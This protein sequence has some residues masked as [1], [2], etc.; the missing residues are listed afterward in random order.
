MVQEQTPGTLELNEIESQYEPEEV[1]RSVENWENILAYVRIGESLFRDDLKKFGLEDLGVE[2]SRTHSYDDIEVHA[3]TVAMVSAPDPEAIM[4]KSYLVYAIHW[5]DD[6]MDERELIE[7]P[8]VLLEN[9][10]DIVEVLKNMAAGK[11]GFLMAEKS[12]NPE[13]TNKGIHRMLYGGLIPRAEGAHERQVLIQEYV[14]LSKTH[15]DSRIADQIDQ[16][17]PEVYL[18]T[19]KV[20]LEG[21]E[22]GDEDFDYTRAELW[23]RVYGPLIYYHDASKEEERGEI[24]FNESEKP[25]KEEMVKM[26]T[27]ALEEL[28][29]Y[30]DMKR[31]KRIEQ[32]RFLL[33]ASRKFLPAE[34]HAVYQRLFDAF[35]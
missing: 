6:F 17:Q 33:E 10:N 24:K 7:N 28:K 26:I 21:V 12:G 13:V 29:K 27:S 4:L 23:N 16:F 34:V 20:I 19:N 11:A 25:R 22:A 32:A 2:T 8:D 14:A 3:F 1:F 30:P 5:L 9:R 18:T 31:K 15:V 35:E